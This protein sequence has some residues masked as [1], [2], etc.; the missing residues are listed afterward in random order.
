MRALPIAL[1]VIGCL[2]FSLPCAADSIALD[3]PSPL[4]DG[5]ILQDGGSTVISL[6]QFVDPLVQPTRVLSDGSLQLTG[7]ALTVNLPVPPGGG[8]IDIW[9]YLDSL[10]QSHNVYGIGAPDPVDGRNVYLS[11]FIFHENDYAP[12]PGQLIIA[13]TGYSN[14]IYDFR[15][16]Q[17]VPEP[18]SL[19]LLGTGILAAW[20][21]R[22][23]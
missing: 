2:T 23:G 6:S 9:F 12:H 4:F 8:T 17:P 5:L 7:E 13:I 16:S 3:A 14:Q 19:L 20:R 15:V 11:S 1:I 18:A 22:I 21:R 10:L